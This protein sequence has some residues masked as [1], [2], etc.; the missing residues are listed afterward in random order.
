[1]KKLLLLVLFLFLL[2]FGGVVFAKDL[3]VKKALEFAVTRLTGFETRVQS[4]HLDLAQPSV[5]V[6]G[7]RILNPEQFK[8]RTFAD[9]PEIYIRPDLDAILKR[10]SLHF[11]EIRFAVN[12]INI[13]KT[14]EGVSNLQLLTSVG[15]AK[16]EPA[17]P[18]PKKG[19]PMPFLLDRLELTIRRV[20]FADHSGLIPKRASADLKV[21]KEVFENIVEPQALVNLILMKIMYGT[22]FGN[23]RDLGIDPGRL[24]DS[25]TKTVDVG[26]ELVQKAGG[27]VVDKTGTV[28]KGTLTEAGKVVGGAAD[29]LDR[30]PGKP[31]TVVKGTVTEATKE[32]GDLFGKLKSRFPGTGTAETQESASSAQTTAASQT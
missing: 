6:D 2:L 22:T 17:P 3:I 11:P 4:L 12:E 28:V 23:L 5:R 25:L 1:M 16:K 26:E 19:E 21:D 9:I 27:L 30:V 10:K 7:L 32:I 8:T 31:G 29:V 14:K 20:G 15:K 18:E 13:E 24:Q